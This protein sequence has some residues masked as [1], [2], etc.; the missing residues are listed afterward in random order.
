MKYKLDLGDSVVSKEDGAEG[1][2]KFFAFK[3]ELCF[4]DVAINFVH[5]APRAVQL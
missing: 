1:I 5:N 4:L 2:V 3:S